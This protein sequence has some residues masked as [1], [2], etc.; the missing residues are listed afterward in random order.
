MENTNRNP[1]QSARIAPAAEASL[2]PRFPEIKN[3]QIWPD[4]AGKQ[5]FS[6]RDYLATGKV[7]MIDQYGNKIA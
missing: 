6:V 5:V 7:I 1:A 2:K 3:G 4:C